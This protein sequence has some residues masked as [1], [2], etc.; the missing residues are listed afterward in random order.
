MGSWPWTW[1]TQRFLRLD[2]FS[3]RGIA[4]FWFWGEILKALSWGPME[5]VS[6]YSFFIQTC[7]ILHILKA[8]NSLVIMPW[9]DK[10]TKCP[11]MNFGCELQLTIKWNPRLQWMN[12]WSRW[13]SNMEIQLPT[14]LYHGFIDKN[15]LNSIILQTRV[16]YNRGNAT[17]GFGGWN[18][19]ALP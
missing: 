10:F 15:L 12:G 1:C 18:F 13:I 3:V 11:W 17:F 19:K 9:W 2:F 14:P 5:S 7:R 16:L 4:T 6:M 8:S